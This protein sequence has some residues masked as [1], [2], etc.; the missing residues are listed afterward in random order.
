VR[1]H[2]KPPV[3]TI[4]QP[5][6]TSYPHS[7]TLILNYTV[8][9][10]GSGVATILPAMDGSAT[11]AGN[12][13]PS[14]EA[15]LLLTSLP[16]GPNTFK[17]DSADMVGNKSSSSVTFNI[18]VTAQSMIDDL[19]ILQGQGLAQ[20]GNS[21]LAKL[22]NAADDFTGGR[23]RVAANKYSA[24]I[25]EVN[26]QTGKSITPAAAALLIGDA[27]YLIAHCP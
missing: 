6:A 12:G 26:A 8:T 27:Q 24:F 15:I 18:I 13:L 19:S 1:F 23:C 22:T 14:G 7:A 2:K 5:A 21:L 4:T 16:L 10:G 11:V 3:I 17:I 9:D 20:Q 25:N